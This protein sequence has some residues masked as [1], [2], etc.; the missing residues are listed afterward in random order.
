MTGQQKRHI[1][2]SILTKAG[3]E[4]RESGEIVSRHPNRQECEEAAIAAARQVHDEGGLAQA[5]LHKSD[6]VIR[7]ERTYGKDSERTPG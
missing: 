4:V 5:V 1:F 3:W 7:E 6:G 2:H